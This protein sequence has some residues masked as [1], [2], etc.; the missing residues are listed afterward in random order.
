MC[1][2]VFVFIHIGE[3]L[4]DSLPFYF[5]LQEFALLFLICVTQPPVFYLF[6]FLIFDYIMYFVFFFDSNSVIQAVFYEHFHPLI[7]SLTE[8]TS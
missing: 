6:S 7:G 2:L 3:K 4:P 8:F 1:F 5:Y